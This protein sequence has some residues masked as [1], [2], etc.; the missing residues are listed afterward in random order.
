MSLR[1]HF[2]IY[3]N[4]LSDGLILSYQQVILRWGGY[5]KCINE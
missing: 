4:T 3:L 1:T 5:S 2:F